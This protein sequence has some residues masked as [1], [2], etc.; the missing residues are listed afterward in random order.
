[1]RFCS[2]CKKQFEIQSN[3]VTCPDDGELLWFGTFKGRTIETRFVLEEELEKTALGE[4]YRAEDL[5]TGKKVAV[6]VLSREFTS[7]VEP[8]ALM[9]LIERHRLIETKNV[10][11][12]IA[13]GAKPVPYI[14][15]T[16]ESG[17]PLLWLLN[18]NP[19][20][21]ELLRKIS[22]DL[23]E[24]LLEL[25]ELGAVH[26][27]LSVRDISISKDGGG[28]HSAYINNLG[29]ADLVDPLGDE[30]EYL[31][32]NPAYMSPE[33]FALEK[34]KPATDVYSMAVCL[35]E[36]LTGRK[37]FKGKNYSELSAAHRIVNPELLPE[38][39][40]SFSP[41][42]KNLAHLFSIC[43]QKRA[44]DRPRAV[45]VLEL[46]DREQ[47]AAKKQ[48]KGGMPSKKVL[49]AA[50]L[51]L[52]LLAGAAYGVYYFLNDPV[53]NASRKVE[54]KKSVRESLISDLESDP[55][56]GRFAKETATM[57]LS[58]DSDANINVYRPAGEPRA[59]ILLVTLPRPSLRKLESKL[60][61]WAAK[62][63]LVVLATLPRSARDPSVQSAALAEILS[64]AAETYGLQNSAPLKMGVLALDLDLNDTLDALSK[65]VHAQ[66]RVLPNV[67]ALVLV[68]PIV[69]SELNTDRAHSITSPVLTIVD[70]EMTS[71]LRAVST[72]AA[73]QLLAFGGGRQILM[74]QNKAGVT[75]QESDRIERAI[76]G[77]FI[78]GFVLGESKKKT[79]L[80]GAKT[81]MSVSSDADYRFR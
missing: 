80:F 71:G 75:E 50:G 27:A 52:V 14:V 7:R 33:Q 58:N 38:E 45:R 16:Y 49:I 13:S 77:G 2:K 10:S 17:T 24:A 51:T 34:N 53:L 67:D 48:T 44:D 15:S 8:A 81:A 47:E 56:S 36:A 41:G 43:M 60:E 57:K 63:A 79:Q 12:V 9:E 25:H 32:R 70:K 1:M 3:Y 59:L 74:L 18:G 61:Q 31:V 69:E 4:L 22:A 28:E 76:V 23:A 78:D 54:K 42:R 29:L 35:F 39:E 68:D 55:G 21:E 19:L 5:N 64:K 62:N 11:K 37:T 65:F 73:E 6:R 66:D 30:F 46:L 20:A 72:R 26:G 40:Q